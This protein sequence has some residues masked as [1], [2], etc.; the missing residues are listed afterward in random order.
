MVLNYKKFPVILKMTDPSQYGKY[1]EACG[2]TYLLGSKKVAKISVFTQIVF[3]R[4]LQVTWGENWKT[5]CSIGMHPVIFERLEEYT[6]V[7]E[8]AKS[9]NLSLCVLIFQFRCFC[10]AD[11]IIDAERFWTGGYRHSLHKKCLWCSKEN[12]EEI[13]ATFSSDGGI[14]NTNQML[15]IN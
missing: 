5:C 8:T 14:A 4:L 11:E 13:D 12:T 7:R 15:G 9:K 6:C 3:L 10:Y 2:N 1:L